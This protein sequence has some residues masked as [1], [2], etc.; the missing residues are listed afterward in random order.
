M[1]DAQGNGL[2]LTLPVGDPVLQRWVVFGGQYGP[3]GGFVGGP[4]PDGAGGRWAVFGDGAVD[5]S[6][7]GLHEVHGY[8]WQHWRDLGSATGFLGHP[9]TDETATAD[10]V[11]RF[12]GFGGG[13]IYWS[14]ATGAHELHGQLWFAWAGRG[15]EQGQLGYPTTDGMAV[16]DGRGITQRFQGGSAW[17][18]AAT[19]VHVLLP[20]YEIGWAGAGG[21]TGPLGYPVTD[22]WVASGIGIT[23]FE[24][25]G[26]YLTPTGVHALSG[27][28]YDAY[29]NTGSVT[30][31]LGAPTSGITTDRQLRVARF[32]HGYIA[33]DPAT[34][35]VTVISGPDQRPRGPLTVVVT[36]AP[37]PATP[38]PTTAPPTA[39]PTAAPEPTSTT[40]TTSTTRPTATFGR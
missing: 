39:P 13:A 15:A 36:T 33:W 3:L 9:N 27:P 11:G 7:A 38:P 29:V 25:G 20:P 14:P 5:Q 4:G 30:G 10:G 26:V 12:N 21:A 17:A 8:V 40:P 19:G 6:A 34:H 18:T 31:R 37:G 35:K 16:G 2:S 22:A 28:I 24:H 23:S 1:F 32:A